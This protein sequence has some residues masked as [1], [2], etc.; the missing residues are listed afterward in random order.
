[1]EVGSVSNFGSDLFNLTQTSYTNH[2]YLVE[3]HTL[4]YIRGK[5]QP[6]SDV[7][8]P[9]PHVDFTWDNVS[10]SNTGYNAVD[11][12]LDING[13]AVTDGTGYKWIVFRFKKNNNTQVRFNGTNYNLSGGA[14][15]LQSI[16][17][18]YFNGSVVDD[19]F[20]DS[21]TNAI[22]FFTIVM[23]TDSGTNSYLGALHVH[24]T[25][26]TNYISTGTTSRTLD[27][28]VNSSGTT[29]N[30]QHG[31]R[32]GSSGSYTVPLALSSMS[33]NYFYVYIGLK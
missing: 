2:T 20:N 14:L 6:K 11:K 30:G 8:Y 1:M 19:I 18:S 29:N 25:A 21:N 7:A 23:T 4:L 32:L 13:N 3:D 22:G 10:M 27:F 15:G 28:L 24:Q 16:L 5:F 12:G 31:A 26:T 9:T 17:D 33:G